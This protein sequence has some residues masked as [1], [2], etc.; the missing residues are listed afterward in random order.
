MTT[1]INACLKLFLDLSR[2]P[3]FPEK[4]VLAEEGKLFAKVVMTVL[5]GMGVRADMEHASMRGSDAD[6]AKEKAC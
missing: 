3:R 6:D 4:V 1:P 2:P 5:F